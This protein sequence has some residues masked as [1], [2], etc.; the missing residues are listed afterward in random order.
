MTRAAASDLASVSN[1]E[2]AVA[3]VPEVDLD[4]CVDDGDCP[5]AFSER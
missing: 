4:K 1:V 2:F 3:G 5:R